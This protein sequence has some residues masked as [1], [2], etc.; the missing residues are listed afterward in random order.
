P[1]VGAGAAAFYQALENVI[2]GAPAGVKTLY[3]LV[4]SVGQ[5]ATIIEYDV[6]FDGD[7][8]IEIDGVLYDSL[9]ANTITLSITT[10]AGLTGLTAIAVAVGT[11][12]IYTKLKDSAYQ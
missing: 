8:N 5:A 4:S 12:I 1:V 7:G 6:V 9:A 10:A 2:N 11:S 3:F